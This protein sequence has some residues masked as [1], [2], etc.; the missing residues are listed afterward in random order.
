MEDKYLFWKSLSKILEEFGI[1]FG[2]DLEEIHFLSRGIVGEMVAV[3]KERY[4]LFGSVFGRV[5]PNHES[6]LASWSLLSFRN[7]L[8]AVVLTSQ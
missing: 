3:K 7:V 4:S 1:D 5:W 2:R 6:K 8:G